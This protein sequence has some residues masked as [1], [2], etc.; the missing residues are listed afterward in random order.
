MGATVSVT[1]Y[2]CI[3]YYLF[4]PGVEN[5]RD[6]TAGPVSRDQ[7]LLAEQR[8]HGEKIVFPV[9]LTASSTVGNHTRLMPSLSVENEQADAGRDG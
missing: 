9:Q 3:M 1:I 2:I 4:Q 5:E 8:Q 6:G 7:I